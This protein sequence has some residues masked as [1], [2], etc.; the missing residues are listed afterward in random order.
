MKEWALQKQVDDT[1]LLLT[2]MELREFHVFPGEVK[3][4][5][6]ILQSN[7]TIPSQVKLWLYY[8]PNVSHFSPFQTDD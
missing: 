2:H 5:V 1:A 3:T 4:S 6:P 8:F 7:M